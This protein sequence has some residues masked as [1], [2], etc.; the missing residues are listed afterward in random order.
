MNDL[1][2]YNAYKTFGKL[3]IEGR[4]DDDDDRYLDV[5]DSNLFM[6]T[7]A[8]Q[9]RVS[10]LSERGNVKLT[11]NEADDIS[12]HETEDDLDEF[13]SKVRKEFPET[14]IFEKFEVDNEDGIIEFE[15]ILPDTITSWDITGFTLSP[16][17]GLGIAKPANVTVTQTFFLDVHL[18]LIHI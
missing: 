8:F 1:Q 10:C 12:L 7:N 17:T 14:W 6:I 2:S 9:G 4:N 11:T 15:Q 16:T 3:E 13:E 5:G 18:S